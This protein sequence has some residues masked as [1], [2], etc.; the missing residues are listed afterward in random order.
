MLN[1]SNSAIFS[2]TNFPFPPYKPNS[3]P[4][5]YAIRWISI[6]SGNCVI[7]TF[8][9]I[10]NLRSPAGRLAVIADRADLLQRG[11]FKTCSK[12][13]V[14][15]FSL[16]EFIGHRIRQHNAVRDMLLRLSRTL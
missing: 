2:L 7:P 15:Y 4:P 8:S 13:Q 11:D 1:I 16:D 12:C 14:Q 9:K 5:V 6:P 10:Y 3:E